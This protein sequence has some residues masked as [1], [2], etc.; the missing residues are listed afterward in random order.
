MKKYIQFSLILLLM[1]ISLTY[2]I[3]QTNANLNNYDSIY[4]KKVPTN[5]CFV[6]EISNPINSIEKSIKYNSLSSLSNTLNYNTSDIPSRYFF[7]SSAFNLKKGMGYYSNAFILSNEFTYA[8]TNSISLTTG[9]LLIPPLPS[10]N[11][12]GSPIWLKAKVAFPIFKQKFHLGGS[13][14]YLPN[15]IA[16]NKRGNSY[17]MLNTVSTLGNKNKNISFGINYSITNNDFKLSFL[18][19]SGKIKVNSR[20]YIIS[21]NYYSFDENFN[22]GALLIIGPRIIVKRFIFEIAGMIYGDSFVY[23][24]FKKK[25]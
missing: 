25:F 19:L 12:S 15:T 16:N 23:V 21:D 14:T 17:F 6:F 24:G 9:I 18:T 2:I 7:S 8:L 4:I 20:L 3:S 22:T 5:S 11:K 1:L 10:L 13:L